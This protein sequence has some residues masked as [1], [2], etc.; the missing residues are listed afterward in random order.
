MAL[1]ELLF[2]YV[3]EVTFDPDTPLLTVGTS[4]EAGLSVT[5]SNLQL[6]EFPD[7]G[8]FLEFDTDNHAVAT[9]VWNGST[10]KL[11]VIPVAS[12]TASVTVLRRK[13]TVTPRLPIVPALTGAIAITV[14]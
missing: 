4:A 5:M 3:T 14:T 11:S 13:G 8:S 12:G 9:V 10:G 6:M 2:P 7:F 1:E